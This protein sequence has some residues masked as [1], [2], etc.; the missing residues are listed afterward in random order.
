MPSPL[1]RVG[2]KAQ[3]ALENLSARDGRSKAQIIEEALVFYYK[4]YP[5]PREASK[6]RRGRKPKTTEKQTCS[7]PPSLNGSES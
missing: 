6:S 2:T 3:K 5:Q 7:Q 4:N 1:V